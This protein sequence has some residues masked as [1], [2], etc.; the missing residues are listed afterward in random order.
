MLHLLSHL[1]NQ[2]LDLSPTRTRTVF[3]ICRKYPGS[4]KITTHLDQQH[5]VEIGLSSIYH[6]YSPR[7]DR[8]A[9]PQP[10]RVPNL[11]DFHLSHF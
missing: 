6:K 2:H 10:H 3:P 5:R 8:L 11:H 1:L 7:L 9:H 4:M